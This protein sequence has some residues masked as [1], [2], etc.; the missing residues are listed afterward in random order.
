MQNQVHMNGVKNDDINQ[1]VDTINRKHYVN[2][3]AWRLE[4]RRQKNVGL[5][6]RNMKTNIFHD[7]GKG[8]PH[9]IMGH[10]PFPTMSAMKKMNP[11][12]V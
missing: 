5:F 12:G 1:N 4:G 3:L 11:H 9:G 10:C 6:T 2:P 8:I 7:G